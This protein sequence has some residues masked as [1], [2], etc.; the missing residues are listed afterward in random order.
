LGLSYVV[1]GVLLFH[2]FLHL[3]FSSFDF[4][5]QI[6]IVRDFALILEDEKEPVLDGV[7]VSA[8]N[9]LHDFR[10]FSSILQKQANKL[11][12]LI[13]CPLTPEITNILLF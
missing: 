4:S 13:F 8:F 6:R 9:K 5:D 2:N 7:L 10:P 12:V 11:I 1:C 3:L